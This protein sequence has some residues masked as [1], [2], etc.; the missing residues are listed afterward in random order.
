[1]TTLRHHHAHTNLQ[2]GF[3]AALVREGPAMDAL[4]P[5]RLYYTVREAADVLR[6]SVVT[7]Y[8]KTRTKEI[9]CRYEGRKVLIPAAYVESRQ[10]NPDPPDAPPRKRGRGRPRKSGPDWAQ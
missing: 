9:P 5:P 8:R 10:D 1:V 4:L 7:V 6:M 2:K 3:A